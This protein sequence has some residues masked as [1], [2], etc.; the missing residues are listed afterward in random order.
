[1]RVRPEPVKGEL[2]QI[3]STDQ[4]RPGGPQPGNDRGI[5]LGKRGIASEQRSG[6]RA[7][8]AN[9]EQILDRHE[10]AIQGR[11]RHI[12]TRPLIGSIGSSPRPLARH[13]KERRIPFALGII[14]P[15]QRRFEAV[16]HRRSAGH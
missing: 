12:Q 4:D 1:M 15:F 5:L 3:R 6:R 8:A 14:D 13:M 2:R 9:V 7:L 16:S 10:R 11:K